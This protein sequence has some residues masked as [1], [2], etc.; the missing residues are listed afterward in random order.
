MNERWHEEN[1]VDL[2]LIVK[3]EDW[4]GVLMIELE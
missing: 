1:G 2:T 3:S 4:L